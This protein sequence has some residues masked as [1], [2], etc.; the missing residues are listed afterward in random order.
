MS[1]AVERPMKKQKTSPNPQ[2]ILARMPTVLRGY[3]LDFGPQ[4]R[5]RYRLVLQDIKAYGIGSLKI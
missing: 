4:H 5:E 1:G 3:I 2:S